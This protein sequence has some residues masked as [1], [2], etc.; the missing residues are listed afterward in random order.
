MSLP[1]DV[2][3]SS[4]V[5]LRSVWIELLEVEK[6]L[7]ADNF[8]E[9]GGNSLLAT[10]LA[11]RIEEETGFALDIQDIF[12]LSFEELTARISLQPDG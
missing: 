5:I 8:I 1:T 10:I 4:L 7:P 3:G 11:T 9:M 2:D 6:I 12:E